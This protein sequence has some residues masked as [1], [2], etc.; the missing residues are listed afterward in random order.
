VLQ[1]R[2]LRVW[3]GAR[4]ARSQGA[5][6]APQ[7]CTREAQLP[8]VRARFAKHK[9]GQG[10]RGLGAARLVAVV[11]AVERQVDLGVGGGCGG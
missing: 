8:L 3:R 4:K 7:G 6:P 11:V 1:G 9:A 2:A 5:G 10:V